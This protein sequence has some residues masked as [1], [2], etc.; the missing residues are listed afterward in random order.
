MDI[1]SVDW[2][3]PPQMPATPPLVQDDTYHHQNSDEV[4][5]EPYA[6]KDSRHQDSDEVPKGALLA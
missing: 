1:Y 3:V 4:P 6:Q 5:K 2:G